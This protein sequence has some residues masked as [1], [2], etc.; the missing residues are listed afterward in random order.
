MKSNPVYEPIKSCSRAL[1]PS[2]ISGGRELNSWTVE[3]GKMMIFPS[4][5][6][7]WNAFSVHYGTLACGMHQLCTDGVEY[8][9]VAISYNTNG[10]RHEIDVCKVSRMKREPIAGEGYLSQ[11]ASQTDKKLAYNEHDGEQSNRISNGA[12]SQPAF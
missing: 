10:I 8:L 4:D 11:S 7:N 2:A 1:V 9:L 3:G 5:L 6:R 12:V